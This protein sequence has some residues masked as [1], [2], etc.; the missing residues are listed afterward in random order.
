MTV[1]AAVTGLVLFLLSVPV[2]HSQDGWAVT[3][4]SP[5]ICAV[6]GSTVDLP[7]TFTYPETI[8]GQSTIVEG[9][10]WFTG[11]SYPGSVDLKSDPDYSGRVQYPPT[12]NDCTLRITDLQERDA[13]AYLFRFVTNQPGGKFTGKGVTLT[14]TDV[15]VQVQ[16][17]STQAVLRCVTS[18]SSSADPS[19][20]WYQN[21]HEM[22][23]TTSDHTVTVDVNHEYSCAVKGQENHRSTEVLVQGWGVTLP[24]PQICAV[25]GST[26]DLPCTF[27][28][29][30]TIEGQST[31][32]ESRKWF[33]DRGYPGSVDLKSDPDYSGRVQYPPTGNDCTLRIT[34]LQE[35]D[36]AEYW[37]RFETN[38][39]GG[40]F[41]GKG[42]TL[43]ITDVQVQVQQVSTQAVL[44]CVTS[45]SSSADP[46]YVWYQNGHEMTETTSDHTVTVD[47]NHEYSCAVK[48][49]ED[50]R[51]PVVY[52]PK[53][54]SVSVSPSAEI[55]EGSSV[56]LTCS[57]D[58]NPAANYTW[59]KENEDSPLA[60]GHIFTITDV[61]AEH[62][63]NYYCVAQNTRGRHNSTIT[64]T[65]W[66][67]NSSFI[68]NISRTT[69]EVLMMGLLLLLLI[70]WRRTYF[71]KKVTMEAIPAEAMELN[72]DPVYENISAV[73][74]AQREGRC[75]MKS[76]G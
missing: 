3:V 33:T 14:I 65:V 63:G 27:T 69:L 67:E 55:K 43:T 62:S 50:Y 4:P 32:V 10:K 6:K 66:A 41:T 72:S 71:R 29:P 46:S 44:R 18:C 24:S 12:G 42:V 1:R 13:A 17:V 35:R 61:R 20:V 16:Q 38:K 37:F 51:S 76:S 52:G 59:Y 2:V 28:Y 73:T 49:H 57:S 34:D 30:E 56:I 19:Y 45:C 60:S 74:A 36:A 9:R 22:T 64:L 40:S 25:K 7:C 48:G 26:V 15:Q 75:C 21:G 68:A 54:P 5:Q 39:P 47:V 23:E 58:A 53:P 11:R 31:I 70:L 8:E